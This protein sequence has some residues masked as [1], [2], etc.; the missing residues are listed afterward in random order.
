MPAKVIGSIIF[1][2]YENISYLS[3]I[4]FKRQQ[5]GLRGEIRKF[6][7]LQRLCAVPL[8]GHTR[9]VKECQAMGFAEGSGL[10]CTWL[11]TALDMPSTCLWGSSKGTEYLKPTV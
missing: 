4:Q 10:D 2:I 5:F 3:R 1:F 6:F 9:Q 7:N 11:T 8:K